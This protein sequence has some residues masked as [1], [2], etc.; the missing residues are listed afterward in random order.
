VVGAAPLPWWVWCCLP[1]GWLVCLSGGCSLLSPCCALHR[2]PG[3]VSV[4]C[5]CHFP[6]CTPLYLNLPFLRRW[7]RGAFEGCRLALFCRCR[8]VV[9]G[10]PHRCLLGGLCASLGLCGCCCCASLVRG[11]LVRL[12]ASSAAVWRALNSASVFCLAPTGLK[13]LNRS[14]LL[15]FP[16]R[17]GR[18]GSVASLGSS[19]LLPFPSSPFRVAG[20]LGLLCFP[21]RQNR[22]LRDRSGVASALLSWCFS[23]LPWLLWGLLPS[24]TWVVAVIKQTAGG[25]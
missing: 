16:D 4:G 23:L 3:G 21:L 25:P 8:G 20:W 24:G 5:C 2:C 9:W 12:L 1:P 7:W 10:A 17:L 11:V 15:T 14:A 13:A 22:K 18:G 6:P 19:S